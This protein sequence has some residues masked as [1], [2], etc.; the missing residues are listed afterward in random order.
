[1]T[2]QPSN[3]VPFGKHKGKLIEEVLVDDPGYP[4]WLAGQEWFRSKFAVLYHTTACNKNLE[5]INAEIK[6]TKQHLQHKQA[7]IERHKDEEDRYRRQLQ[8]DHS[9]LKDKLLHLLC[10]RKNLSTPIVI[11]FTV[12]TGFEEHGV[13]VDLEI[14]ARSE[15]HRIPD[16]IRHV[17]RIG[18]SGSQW[19]G[20]YWDASFKIEIKPAV[21][22]DYPAVLR[23]MKR[24]GSD[25][26]FVGEYTGQ[27]ATQEQFVK[28]IATAGIR[29]VFARDVE[30]ASR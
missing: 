12:S 16:S 25:V 15:L 4:Q 5:I 6:S 3:I 2:D 7:A 1:M 21:G 17:G 24:T 23:Q 10:A 22:D 20:M 19:Y 13:D 14:S 27:G 28:T 11:G 30:E 8:E 9:R 18:M 26:L 29:V